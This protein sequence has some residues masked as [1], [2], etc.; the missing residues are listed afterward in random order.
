M[1]I[2]KFIPLTIF[3]FVLFSCGNNETEKASE[4]TEETAALAPK[5]TTPV[6]VDDTTKFKFDFAIANIPS[7]AGTMQE[8]NKWQIPYDN[9]LFNAPE[10]AS[11]YDN[12]FKRAINLGVYNIDMCYAMVSEKGEDVLKYMKNVMVISDKLGLKS[13]VNAMVGQRA[14]KNMN[15][16]DSLFKILDEI[17]VKSDDYLRTND[18]VFTATTV[19]T[20]SWLE[21]LY[22]ISQVGAKTTDA[23]VTNKVNTLLWEQR[24][25][26]GNIINL[27]KDY[28]NKKDAEKLVADLEPIHAQITAIKQSKDITPALFK[29]ISDKILGLRTSLIN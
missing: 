7:P 29:S 9:N 13:A 18:R 22:L 5:D 28:K 27:L 6:T 2:K 17:F 8:I 20:G 4:E 23:A 1:F 11:K 16:K 26:L 14:E 12:E 19:F 24:F 10:N 25:H 3:S 21:S 15:N